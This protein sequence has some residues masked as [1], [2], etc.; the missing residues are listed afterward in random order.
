MTTLKTKT[1][2]NIFFLKQKIKEA[3]GVLTLKFLPAK[4]K[5]FSF[6]PGQF[7][8]VSFLDKRASGKIRAYSISSAP[9][10]KFLTITVK[11][12]GVFSAALHNLK[13]GEKIKISSPRGNFY[14]DNSAKNLVFLAGGIGV[15]PFYSIIKDWVSRRLFCK[16]KIT[17]FYSNYVKKEI[18]FFKELNEVADSQ[19]NFKVIYFLTR[20]R[21]ENKKIKEFRRLNIQFRRLNI[22]IV[23]KYLKT[24]KNKH[25]F[26][27]GPNEFVSNL[28]RKLKKSGV[29]KNL[30]KTEA[31]Y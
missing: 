27:C 26:I 3:E 8:P 25:Y 1:Q 7:V 28:Q 14:P 22:R 11:K 16:N 12:V 9:S 31:F 21:I 18:V 5:I 15:A 24:L 19:P 17:L 4:E 13:I 23:K 2:N 29:K 6:Q 10:E 20:E 30:I